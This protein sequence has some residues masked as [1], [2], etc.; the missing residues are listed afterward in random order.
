MANDFFFIFQYKNIT[1]KKLQEIHKVPDSFVPKPAK[2]ATQVVGG[3]NYLYLVKLPTN[4][5]AFISIHHRAWNK[6]HYGKEENVQIRT[7]TYELNDKT[8]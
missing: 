5:Y 2:F 8:V 3:I 4:K 1:L 7:Q 6:S